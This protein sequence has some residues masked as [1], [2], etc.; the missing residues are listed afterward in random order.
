MRIAIVTPAL[1]GSLHGNRRTALR[2]ADL[3]RDGGHQVSVESRWEGTEVDLLLALHARRSHES[4]RAYANASA[5]GPLVVTLTGT[6]LYRDIRDD[7]AAR[8]SVR[9]ATRLVVLQCLG[10][11]ELPPEHRAKVDVVVQSAEPVE[12]HPPGTDGALPVA[13]VGHLRPEKDPFRAALAARL[14]PSESRIE[15]VHAGG[16]HAPELAKE[17]RALSAEVGRYRWLGE[18]SHVEVRELLGR[19]WLLAHTSLLEGGANVVSEALAASLPVVASEI[20]GNVGLL[21][22][23]HPG[24]YRPGDEAALARLLWTLESEPA[25]YAELERRSDGRRAL[26]TRAAERSALLAVVQR[27]VAAAS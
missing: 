11:E 12:R 19:A 7:E 5:G 25:R 13:V 23:D 24:Y 3:L 8:E 20:P 21:G 27:A 2:W 14:L 17:A 16:T 26:V 9:L 18:L 10:V 22:A 6:D 4:V 15:V 1:P